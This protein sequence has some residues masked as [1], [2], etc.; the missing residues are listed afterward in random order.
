MPLMDGL[1]VARRVRARTA[2]PPVLLVA[3]TGWGQ[4]HDKE[5]ALAAGFDLHWVKPVSLA[6]LQSFAGLAAG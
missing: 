4:A 5:A 6:Q 3:L 2:A 1:E